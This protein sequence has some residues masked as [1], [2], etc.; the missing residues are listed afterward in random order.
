MAIELIVNILLFAFAIFAF[1]HVG[2]TMPTSPAT[3]LGAEQWPQLVLGAL[4]IAIAWNVRNYFKRNKKE[5]VAAAF[6]SFLPGVLKFVKS[7]MFI[8]MVLLV[9]MALAYQPVGFMATCLLFLIV[10][11]ILLGERRPLMLVVSSLAVTLIL[12]IGFGVLLRLML[13]RGDI[14]FLRDFAIWIEVLIFRLTS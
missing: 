14:P 8:G 1:F 13:P 6:S 3:Q 10:Y 5:D 12:Y 9:V 2:A 11:G 7:K 4:M